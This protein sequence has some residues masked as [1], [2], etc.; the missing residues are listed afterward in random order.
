MSVS[1]VM[2]TMI[3]Q[4]ATSSMSAD[5]TSSTTQSSGGRPSGETGSGKPIV[6]SVEDIFS[7]YDGDGDDSEAAKN[8]IELKED[9]S[10]IQD[11]LNNTV[12]KE[13]KKEDEKEEK[14]KEDKPEEVKPEAKDGPEKLQDLVKVK[15]NGIEKEVPLQ[16]VINS[17]SGQQE[18]QRRFTEFDKTKK[19]FEAEKKELVGMNNYVKQEIGDLRNA[20]SNVVDQYHKNGTIE[21]DPFEAVNNLLDKMG[22]NSN[23]YQRAVFEHQLP[24]FAKFF[25]M[26]DV[27]RDAYFTRKENDYL[28]KK[29]QGFTERDQQVKLREEQQQKDFELIKSAGLDSV[30]YEN[31]SSELLDAGHK[32]V[33]AEKVVE[34]AKQ[35]PTLEKVIKVFESIGADPAQDQRSRTVFKILQDFPE[36]TIEEIL[37]HMD[38]NR[39]ALKTA[40][41]LN[42]KAPKVNKAPVKKGEDPDFDEMLAFYK[43]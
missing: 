6:N 19:S 28:R 20:F 17:Y 21:K 15:V 2:N 22:I 39:A 10:Q 24:E 38:P 30:Q 43:N 1:D 18:I 34:Y 9:K 27:E 42:D 3:T 5:V 26:T 23:I 13:I 37:D 32:D 29:E 33:T 4:D 40:K 7:I 16:D 31:L 11:E 12:P 36:T 25:D 14:V 41:I 8:G 35:K